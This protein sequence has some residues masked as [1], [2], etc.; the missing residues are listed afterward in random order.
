MRKQWVA[1][2][3]LKSEIV[4]I[5]VDLLLE[6]LQVAARA[7]TASAAQTVLFLKSS[8]VVTTTTPV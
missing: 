6:M 8:A 3:C 1:V 5:R 4:P 2:S 7:A